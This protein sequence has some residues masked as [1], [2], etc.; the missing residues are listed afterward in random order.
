MGGTYSHHVM[1][2]RNWQ[3]HQEICPFPVLGLQTYLWAGAG[4]ALTNAQ[5]EPCPQPIKRIIPTSFSFDL[6][7]RAMLAKGHCEA[8]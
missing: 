1:Q 5:D 7:S 4:G 6:L 3:W 8:T 2:P